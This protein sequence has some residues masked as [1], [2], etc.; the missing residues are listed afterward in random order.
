MNHKIS[1][2]T[3]LKSESNKLKL[4]HADTLFMDSTPNLSS[5]SE[6]CCLGERNFEYFPVPIINKSSDSWLNK[7]NSVSLLI[8]SS[9]DIET[10]S[11]FLEEIKQGIF[12]WVCESVMVDLSIEITVFRLA[13]CWVNSIKWLK[14]LHVRSQL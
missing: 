10:S 6:T 7:G 3:G 1:R 13:L 2:P 4:L 11:T 14:Y 8:S 9:E 12:S 5:D